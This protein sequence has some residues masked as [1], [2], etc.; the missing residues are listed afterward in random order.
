VLIL[1]LLSAVAA[2]AV[3]LSSGR[4]V[5]AGEPAFAREASVT[6]AGPSPAAVAHGV[7]AA[8]RADAALDA[9]DRAFYV[10]QN[11]RGS[12]RV[13]TGSSRLA[14]FWRTAE[15]IEMVE[16]AAERSNS[17][18]YRHMVTELARGVSRRWG[19]QWTHGRR[20]ND[21]VIWMVLAFERASR[22]TGDPHLRTVARRNFDAV[23]A[24]AWSDDFGGGLWWTTD[25]EEKNTCVNA[26]ATIAA[27]R[28][29][30][31]LH[32]SSYLRKARRI[33]AWTRANLF[34]QST[35]AVY[36]LVARN[37][38]QV[39][40]DRATYTY[41]QGTFAGAADLL[42]RT[43]G[44]GSNVGDA[45][46]AIAYAR[47]HLSPNGV[48]R[49]EGSGDGGGFKGVLAR[50]VGEHMR[51]DTTGCCE[52]WMVRNAEAAWAHRDARRLMDHDWSQPTTAGTVRAFDAS[53]AVVLLQ[54]LRGR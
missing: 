12:F 3:G 50:Y 41:N 42:D 33:Y 25:D 49:D 46:A 30:T 35:G 47:D 39:V 7:A 14:A 11:G 32:Q 53:S 40:V 21:D 54:Q 31:A 23:F 45:D 15:M 43:D 38:G 6:A 52:D 51:R 18:T 13:A 1:F 24:R 8:A 10:V 26:P 34:D 16:D 48:L 20:Y 17:S 44:G 19:E 2:A 28:L 9:F 37:G 4:I 29:S 36:D 22:I 5:V 27:V